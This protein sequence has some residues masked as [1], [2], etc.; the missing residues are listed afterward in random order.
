MPLRDPMPPTS[1]TPLS[2]PQLARLSKFHVQRSVDIHCHCL[3]AIDDGPRNL[4]ESIALCRLL[5]RDGFTD[6]V[7]TPHQL[8]RWDGLNWAAEVRGAVADL[9][10]TLQRERIPLRLHPGG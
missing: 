8:G 1:P 6:V 5:V 7:A 4:A 9:Q 10:A 2:A 3:P